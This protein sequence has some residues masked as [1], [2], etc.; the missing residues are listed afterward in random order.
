MSN[1]QIFL[2]FGVIAMAI[3][4]LVRLI[5]RDKREPDEE[6]HVGDGPWTKGG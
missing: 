4:V 2:I 1:A 5:L 6:H 3:V